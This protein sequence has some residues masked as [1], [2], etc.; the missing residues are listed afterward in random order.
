V[1]LVYLQ[2]TTP[3]QNGDRVVLRL[4]A[5]DLPTSRAGV[6]LHYPPTFQVRLADGRFRVSAETAPA[7]GTFDGTA[8]RFR[9]P[10]NAAADA[11]PAMGD[12]ISRYR[13]QSGERLFF[14]VLP[15]D[16]N[17][18]SFGP[19]IF[20]STELVAEDDAPVIALVVKG[21]RS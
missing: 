2:Q 8:S 11:A 16:V 5:L 18:P 7:T 6:R 12:L 17:V 1:K 13:R 4:P 9:S 14:G 15:V 3:W 19:S 20:F 10:V 21:P